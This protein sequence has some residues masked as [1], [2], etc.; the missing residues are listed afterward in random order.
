MQLFRPVLGQ[1]PAALH[2]RN[3]PCR[4]RSG[5]SADLLGCSCLRAR[6]AVTEVTVPPKGRKLGYKWKEG[7][8]VG[9]LKG[10]QKSSL[11]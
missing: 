9:E 4:N 11:T 1:P 3:G 8:I 6:A 7:R 2:P 5:L 10:M